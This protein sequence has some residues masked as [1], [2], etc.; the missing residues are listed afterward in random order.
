ML[1]QLIAEDYVSGD[2][3][4]NFSKLLNGGAFI[5]DASKLIS[6]NENGNGNDFFTNTILQHNIQTI[7]IDRE[8]EDKILKIIESGSVERFK[9]FIRDA[10]GVILKPSGHVSFSLLYSAA[11][12]KIDKAK[13]MI[14]ALFQAGVDVNSF[15]TE[16]KTV[17]EHL[18]ESKNNVKE[19]IIKFFVEHGAA[20]SN[21]REEYSQKLWDFA[22]KCE[23][24]KTLLYEQIKNKLSSYIEGAS[25]FSVVE[26][27][28]VHGNCATIELNNGSKELKISEFLQ[29]QFCQDNGISGFFIPASNRE[30][31]MHGYHSLDGVRHYAVTDGSYEMTLNWYVEGKKCTV[32]ITVSEKGVELIERNGV[33][34]DEL[35]ANKDVTINGF[36][37]FEAIEKGIQKGMGKV[38]NSNSNETLSSIDKSE[39]EDPP[40]TDTSVE[41]LNNSVDTISNVS[42]ELQQSAAPQDDDIG[43]DDARTNIDSRDNSVSTDKIQ[44]G[45]VEVRRSESQISDTDSGIDDEINGIDS[46]TNEN[47]SNGVE[48]NQSQTS[49]IPN[50]DIPG[51]VYATK[52]FMEKL[53]EAVKKKR[54]LLDKLG[55][56]GYEKYVNRCIESGYRPILK[57]LEDL[58]LALD[59]ITTVDE[60]KANEKDTSSE[61]INAAKDVASALKGVTVTAYLDLKKERGQTIN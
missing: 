48:E 40:H 12:L 42:D 3:K 57:Y 18:L 22:K 20:F 39:F 8:K 52:E 1:S 55:P 16:G 43:I 35:K 4:N 58:E 15:D 31:G 33:T 29:E 2:V 14:S 49:S 45:G 25:N 46:Y 7:D 47:I 61:S 30:K 36:S 50:S 13:E 32:T 11:A 27:I 24:G 5:T 28:E 41:Q 60:L 34:N 17:F 6:I 9:E 23:K 44:D 59:S 53:Q 26:N 38:S 56:D 51:R 37:L 19:E 54:E 21:Y 10:E